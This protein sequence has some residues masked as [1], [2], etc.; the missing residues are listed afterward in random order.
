MPTGTEAINMSGTEMHARPEIA[1]PDEDPDANVA[2][3]SPPCF[4]HELDPAYLGYPRVEEVRE[5]LEALLAME[6]PGTLM[7]AA[8]LRAMLRRRLA[9][10]G[11]IRS[12]G[13][14][15]FEGETTTA[16]GV[17]EAKPADDG[18]NPLAQRLREALPRFADDALRRDLG[19]VLR[20]ME[21]DRRRH[22]GSSDE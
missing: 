13:S 9:G 4:L 14:W 16:G 21:R 12:P 22:G 1:S 11:A 8:W 7:E 10:L 2:C 19:E 6:W 15:R 20:M 5:L 3:S 17:P 18:Q